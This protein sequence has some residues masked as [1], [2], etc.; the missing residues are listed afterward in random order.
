MHALGESGGVATMGAPK[1]L[2]L[3][4]STTCRFCSPAATST[5]FDPSEYCTSVTREDDDW[6]LRPANGV[7]GERLNNRMLEVPAADGTY[8]A[9]MDSSECCVGGQY[10][11][12][13]RVLSA[14][15]ASTSGPGVSV[16]VAESS[17]EPLPASA[18][19]TVAGPAENSVTQS[20]NLPSL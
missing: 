1:D 10:V 17:G 18:T 8:E 19:V 11:P 5:H 4:T 3:N 20:E 6:D 7:F 15:S 16:T 2:P 13:P 14:R 9:A 12:G